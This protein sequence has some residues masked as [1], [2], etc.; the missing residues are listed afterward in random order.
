M[1]REREI[2]R[3]RG[4][5]GW[6]RANSR[7]GSFYYEASPPPPPFPATARI[8]ASYVPFRRPLFPRRPWIKPRAPRRGFRSS[9][10]RYYYSIDFWGSGGG[11]R[12]NFSR[13]FPGL[14]APADSTI[15]FC[16]LIDCD[17]YHDRKFNFDLI[18]LE[19]F[20][21]IIVIFICGF[22]IVDC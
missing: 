2:E 10:W 19:R 17:F 14:R 11:L 22:R 6:R 8:A 4:R 13:V 7:S 16:H 9:R 18:L 1:E 15:L 21:I 12:G 5:E 20:G 3:R